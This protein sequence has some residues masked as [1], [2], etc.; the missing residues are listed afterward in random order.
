MYSIQYKELYTVYKYLLTLPLTQ[1]TCERT[2]SKLKL[3][4]TRLRSTTSQENLECLF[5]MQCE[6][7]ILN[8]VDGNRI[9]DKMCSLS[10]EINRLLS[11]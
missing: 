5:L 1:V 4:K 10:Q 11:L 7:D 3:L 6:R 8:Q 9:I 2:F